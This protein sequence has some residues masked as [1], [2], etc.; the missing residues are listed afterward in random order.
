MTQKSGP[1]QDFSVQ[2]SSLTR[3]IVQLE[4]VDK[5]SCIL[6]GRNAF[7]VEGPAK[8][9]TSNNHFAQQNDS[10]SQSPAANE[11]VPMYSVSSNFM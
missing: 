3:C 4:L 9:P 11:D 7:K 8:R 6:F 2:S 1:Y 5:V 10:I